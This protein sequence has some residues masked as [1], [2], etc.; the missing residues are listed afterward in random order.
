M[1]ALLIVTLGLISAISPAPAAAQEG[2]SADKT[3][4]LLKK[5]TPEE[6]AALS[7]SDSANDR[8]KNY[9]RVAAGRL[10]NA[11]ALLDTDK[12]AEADEQIQIYT[13]VI[14]DAGRFLT[15]VRARDKA[16]K[17]MEQGLKEQLRLLEGIRRNTP[18]E[19]F[20]VADDA[21]R[22]SERV[23]IQALKAALAADDLLKTPSQKL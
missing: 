8:V 6:Q 5:L 23:R 13:A 4:E 10:K 1:K 7:K 20:D 22:T 14:N 18:A 2:Q 11:R 12:Y 3:N 17:T 9:L 16:H 15:S 19:H 21:V